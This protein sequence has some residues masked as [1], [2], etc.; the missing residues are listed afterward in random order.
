MAQ[1][2]VAEQSLE[3][4]AEA[5]KPGWKASTNALGGPAADSMMRS[6]S[7]QPDAVLPEVD[8][9]MEKYFGSSAP[10]P[11]D[12]FSSDSP[13]AGRSGLVTM[14]PK[15]AQDLRPGRKTVFVANN[16]IVGEQG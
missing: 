11:M 12:A 16:E 4:I 13:A 7:V 5:A 3:E 1:H 15:E 9:L 6:D 8:T 14:E 10:Q 2:S